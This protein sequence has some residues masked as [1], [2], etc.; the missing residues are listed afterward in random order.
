[1]NGVLHALSLRPVQLAHPSEQRALLYF[2]PLAFTHP[3]VPMV[4][5]C[6]R[7]LAG[8]FQFLESFCQ[9]ILLLMGGVAAVGIPGISS[10]TP[11][12]ASSLCGWLQ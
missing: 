4:L 6:L 8:N 1:M 3:V 2:Q 7:L 12:I 9:F 5:C 10:N 11:S